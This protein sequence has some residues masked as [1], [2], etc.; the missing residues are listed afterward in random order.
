MLMPWTLAPAD[1]D[2]FDNSP[3]VWASSSSAGRHTALAWP[4]RRQNFFE[5]VGR[6]APR[7]LQASLGMQN[8][9][10]MKIEEFLWKFVLKYH[11]FGFLQRFL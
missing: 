10:P 4:W 3:A 7:Y 11:Q 9:N 6:W 5:E 2:V 1:V 8:P